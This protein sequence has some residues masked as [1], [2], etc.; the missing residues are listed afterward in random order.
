MNGIEFLHA[1]GGHSF[2]PAA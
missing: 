2:S 1:D